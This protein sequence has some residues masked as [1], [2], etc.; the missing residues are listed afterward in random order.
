MKRLLFIFCLLTSP[1]LSQTAMIRADVAIPGNLDLGSSKSLVVELPNSATGTT[2][3]RLAKRVVNGGVVQAQVLTTSA[4]DQAAAFGCTVSGAGASGNAVILVLGVA[5]CV[6]DGATTAGHAGVPSSTIAGALHDT[7]SDSAPASGQGMAYAQATDACGSPPC[8]VSTWMMPPDLIAP[9]SGGAGGNNGNGN[10]NS[11]AKQQ[12]H[13]VSFVIDGNGSTI[14]TGD[15][16]VYIPVASPGTINRWDLSGDSA[17]SITIDVWAR[18]A[19]IPT[20][21]QKIS[22][23]APMTLSS[24]QLA[25]NGSRSGWTNAVSS[26]YVF[27]FSV[28]TVTACTRVTGV[29]WYQ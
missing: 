26:G 14:A 19:A 28:A 24:A 21:S 15:I 20:G 29:V 12:Q 23:S 16:G 4:A 11:G 8:S 27:G 2:A 7:G 10:S 22:A 17:C 9:G 3:N 13:S 6:W 25:Q 18:S 1:L 5:N